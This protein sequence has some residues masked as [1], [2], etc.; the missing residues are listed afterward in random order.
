MYISVDNRHLC[1]E[2][3]D[4]L[5]NWQSGDITVEQIL[6]LFTVYSCQYFGEVAGWKCSNTKCP[7]DN[8]TYLL[9]S[10][11]KQVPNVICRVLLVK[12]KGC[13]VPDILG[14]QSEYFRG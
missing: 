9:I 4:K 10:L 7:H 13:P 14:L 3:Q 5:L 2:W 12:L 6:R 8:P 11:L 1:G